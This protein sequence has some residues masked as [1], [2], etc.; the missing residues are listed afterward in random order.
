M[1]PVTIWHNPS[2][3]TSRT[4]LQAIRDHGIEPVIVPYL[5]TPPDRETLL[6]VLSR[7]GAGPRD[8]LRRR[9]NQALLDDALDDD[10]LLA[11]M[12]AHPI[13]IE[14]PIVITDRGA[15]LCRPADRLATVL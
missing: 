5:K 10:A 4:V 7:M 14:R 12:L 13:L 2:C 9:G 8:I 11:R 6:D 3:G 1:R 15:V